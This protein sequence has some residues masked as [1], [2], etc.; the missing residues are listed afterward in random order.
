MVWSS[1]KKKKKNWHGVIIWLS[2]FKQYVI[3]LQVYGK[4]LKLP[5]T[6]RI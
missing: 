3:G 6:P 2:S 1:S 5:L 4:K